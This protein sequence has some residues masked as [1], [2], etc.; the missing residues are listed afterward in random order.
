MR[1]NGLKD[2]EAESQW[3][4]DKIKRLIALKEHKDIEGEMYM[5]KLRFLQEIN[6]SLSN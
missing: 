2:E 6:I 1:L 5:R 4:V 3:V